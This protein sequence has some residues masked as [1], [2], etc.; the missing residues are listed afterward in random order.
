MPAKNVITNL[1]PWYT[2]VKKLNARSAMGRSWRHGF[3]FLQCLRNPLLAAALSQPVQVHAVLAGMLAGPAHARCLTLINAV[4]RQSF[5]LTKCLLPRDLRLGTLG[6]PPCNRRKFHSFPDISSIAA[7]TADGAQELRQFFQSVFGDW[8]QTPCLSWRMPGLPALAALGRSYWDFAGRF[9]SANCWKCSWEKT[10]ASSAWCGS[11]KGATPANLG[12]KALP[13]RPVSG[14]SIFAAV[15]SSRP[16][17][18][19]VPDNSHLKHNRSLA[20]V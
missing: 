2:E 20:C 16:T 18:S 12:W 3:L 19:P 8:T 17:A 10:S 5:E 15:A 4:S 1:K 11:V 14:I 13:R 9:D 7:W 6:T